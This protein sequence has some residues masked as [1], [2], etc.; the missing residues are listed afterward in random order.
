MTGVSY[1]HDAIVK[2]LEENHGR[3]PHDPEHGIDLDALTPNS[4]LRAT[5][6]EYI[7]GVLRKSQ[8][9]EITTRAANASVRRSRKKKRRESKKKKKEA[10]KE[11]VH[12]P[13][14]WAEAD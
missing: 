7:R 9:E 1:E 12:A 11:V 3:D 5:T 13:S 4:A 2:W 10:P 14:E 8:G 6:E